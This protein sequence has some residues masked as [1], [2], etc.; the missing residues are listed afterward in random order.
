MTLVESSKMGKGIYEGLEAIL[1][2]DGNL[3]KGYIPGRAQTLI[4]E[5]YNLHKQGLK[6]NWERVRKG[7]PSHWIKPLR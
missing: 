5:W 2:F 7:E 4:R 3:L 6:E 1:G